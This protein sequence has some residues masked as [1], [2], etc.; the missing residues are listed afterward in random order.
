MVLYF[1][2]K[3]LKGMNMLTQKEA[4]FN[5]ITSYFEDNGIDFEPGT[6]IELSKEQ[7]ASITEIVTAGIEAN[8]VAFSEA[9]K[10]KYADSDKIKG[11]VSN[12]VGNW[13]TKDPDLNGGVKYEPKNP[14]SR[15]GQGDPELRELKKLLKKVT[16]TGSDEHIT[17]VQTAIDERMEVLAIS[18]VKD[19]NIDFTILPDSLSHLNSSEASS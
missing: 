19:V 10:A 4:V 13:L 2:F 14:G 9:A 12:M 18:K 5:A 3:Y 6:K 7:R 1:L 11:Y 16:A 17:A 8:E 15:A